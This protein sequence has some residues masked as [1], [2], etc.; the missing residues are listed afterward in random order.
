MLAISQSGTTYSYLSWVPSESGPLVTQH[1]SI[2]KELEN[3]D[4]IDEHYYEIL[5]EIFSQVKNGDPICTFS[6]DSGSVLF[7]TCYAENASE[8]MINWHLNQSRDDELNKVMD[9]YHFSFTPESGKV[10]NMGIPKAIRNSFQTNMSLLKSKMNGL[11]VGIF[12]AEVGAR[13]WMHAYKNESYLIWKI[14]KKKNDEL[15]FIKNGELATYFS[16]H[17]SGKKSKMLWQ[18][19]DGDIANLIMQD[20][21]NV[22]DE[23]AKKFTSAQQVYLYTTDGN[24]K[25][26][27]F[28]NTL[29]LENLTLLNPLLIL[30]SS[31][32]IKVH[33]YNTLAL[34]ETGNSFGGI[35]V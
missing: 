16:F 15:L 30:E 7:S 3:P 2:E 19:G 24:M 9:Y 33:E 13:Q 10:L 5:D 32:E 1:G 35:D 29:E 21:I 31:E 25:D 28:F 27:K 14:G 20:I 4:R 18:F 8:E 23:K 22:Q 12:S 17:R 6:L 34:A 11:S 26:V